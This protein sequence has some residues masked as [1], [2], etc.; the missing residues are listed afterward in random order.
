MRAPDV[1][2]VDQLLEIPVD[3]HEAIGEGHH[4]DDPC[5]LRGL[6][7]LAG[8]SRREGQRLLAQHV[9]APVERRHHRRVVVR[10]G[11][12]HE[13]R[14]QLL[15]SEQGVQR[16]VGRRDGP[17]RGELASVIG[18]ASPAIPRTSASGC[19][20]RAGRYIASAHQLVP[21]TPMRTFLLMT[22][23]AR[24]A[25][26][27]GMLGSEPAPAHRSGSGRTMSRMRPCRSW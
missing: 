19:F 13:Q 4:G 8:L 6:G 10:V 20:A 15:G 5:P 26:Q 1:P 27:T 17:L 7:H 2:V 3:G 9:E 23:L 25:R 22:S 18:T 21:T 11:G 14:V 12:E 16:V 24:T